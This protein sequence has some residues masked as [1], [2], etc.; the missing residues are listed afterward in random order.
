MLVFCAQSI[1]HLLPN[2]KCSVYMRNSVFIKAINIGKRF[3]FQNPF[4]TY[5]FFFHMVSLLII[6]ECLNKYFG[7][8]NINGLES[9]IHFLL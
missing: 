2:Q 6:V 1:T 4:W 5:Q 8:E 3:T 9:K 7:F